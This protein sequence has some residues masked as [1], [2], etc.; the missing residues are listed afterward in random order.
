MGPRKERHIGPAVGIARIKLEAAFQFQYTVGGSTDKIKTIAKRQA[1]MGV[2]WIEFDR[3][4][5]LGDS[6][7]QIL[8][9]NISSAEGQVRS[10]RVAVKR[11]G[12]LRCL[13]AA[14]QKILATV[15]ASVR[16]NV[17][18][19]S[20]CK[21]H[22]AFAISPIQPDRPVKQSPRLCVAVSRSQIQL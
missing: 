9:P 18:Q 4:F 8:G 12:L 6:H 13:S 16:P 15:R 20:K 21:T 2:T 3:S 17:S 14:S 1:R 22:E 11:H 7:V 5:G 19:K 10:R